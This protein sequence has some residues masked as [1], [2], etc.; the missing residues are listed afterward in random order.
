M[1]LLKFKID[2]LAFIVAV[3]NFFLADILL[4]KFCH[5]NALLRV[6]YFYFAIATSRTFL[7]SFSEPLKKTMIE[8]YSC[9]F[10]QEKI[11]ISG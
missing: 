3:Q 6:G 10:L 1:Q 9:F 8:T 7:S 11:S 2:S 5:S 4:I